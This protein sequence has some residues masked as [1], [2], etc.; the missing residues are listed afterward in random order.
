MLLANTIRS[1]AILVGITLFLGCAATQ[2]V[3]VLPKGE[4]RFIS[5]IGGPV[6][7]NQLPTPALP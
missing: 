6:L 3:R 7:P 4:R 2:P 5:F 1:M